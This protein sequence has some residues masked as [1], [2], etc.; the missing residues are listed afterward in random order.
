MLKFCKDIFCE[1]PTTHSSS[2]QR[3]LPPHHP[4][5][6]YVTNHQKYTFTYPHSKLQW[7]A[8]HLFYPHSKLQW[9]AH[10]IT[11]MMIPQDWTQYL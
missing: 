3:P 10:E 6:K 4:K 11:T 5:K 8:H 9:D 2:T 7:D 1:N